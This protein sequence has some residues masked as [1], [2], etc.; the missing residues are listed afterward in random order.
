MGPTPHNLLWFHL[1]NVYLT[2]W[3]TR[4][5]RKGVSS[6]VLLMIFLTVM[7]CSID[8]RRITKRLACTFTSSKHKKVHLVH[9][10]V[11]RLKISITN[12]KKKID[13][14]IVGTAYIT[15][16]RRQTGVVPVLPSL[17]ALRSR[18]GL[19]RDC[20]APTHWLDRSLA[21]FRRLDTWVQNEQSWLS[22]DF[23][24]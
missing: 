24:Q 11:F 15:G 10:S 6:Y 19:S 17:D 3:R 2:C 13:A 21:D 14:R 16:K 1:I 20:S 18:G 8:T 5:S 4:W 22:V 12:P 7:E 23:E 9:I